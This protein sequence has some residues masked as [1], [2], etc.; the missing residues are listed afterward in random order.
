MRAW[1]KTW[2]PWLHCSLTGLTSTRPLTAAQSGRSLGTAA[3]AWVLCATGASL[4]ATASGD[5][6]L[7]LAVIH[8]NGQCARVLL[9]NGVRLSMV[10]EDFRHAISPELKA[11]ERGVLRCRAASVAMLRV[12]RAGHLVLWDK[13]LLNQLALDMWATRTDNAWSFGGSSR[14]YF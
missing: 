13:F 9:A 3:C 14:C 12:K 6:P 11:F 2:P 4:R 5:A 7:D 1:V 10:R 8:G